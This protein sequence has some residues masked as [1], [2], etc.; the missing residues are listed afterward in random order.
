MPSNRFGFDAPKDLPVEESIAWGAANGFRY[1]DFNADMPP[2][3]LASFDEARAAKVR[4]LLGETGVQMGV[5]PISAINNAEYV[6]ILSEAVDAYLEANVRLAQRLGCDWI[7][8]HGGYQ[9]G[10]TARRREAAVDRIKRLVEIAGRAGIMVY[11]ENHNKEPDRAE[12]HYLPHN[13]EE[14][15][16]FLEEIDA[17][18]FKWAFNVAHGHLVPEG[19]I[20]FLDAFGVENIGQVRVN[21]NNADYEVHLVPGEGTIDF[22]AL[23]AELNGR[24]YNGWFNLGFGNQ[25]D[26]IRIR[27]RFMK[28]VGS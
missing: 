7:V 8:G 13:V 20:G 4:Q 18:H 14:T 22:D 2:N 26:K 3:A 21:D 5:H 25:A 23:F 24:G 19:W 17:P 11:F 1:L 27:E 15:R 12:M 16:W 6:P 9:F 10:D 28:L